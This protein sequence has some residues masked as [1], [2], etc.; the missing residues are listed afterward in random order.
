MSKYDNAVKNYAIELAR[1]KWGIPQHKPVDHWQYEPQ[2]GR[3]KRLLAWKATAVRS[4]V[5]RLGIVD[6]KTIEYY[7]AEEGLIP[8]TESPLHPK[9]NH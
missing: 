6:E 8:E 2:M 9:F 1:A 4:A 7:L 3:A 5:L